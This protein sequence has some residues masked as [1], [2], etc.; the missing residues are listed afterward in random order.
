[1][2][3]TLGSKKIVRELHRQCANFHDFAPVLVSVFRGAVAL[4]ARRN[5][6]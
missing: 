3:R 5:V 4:L 2:G 6:S 1:M